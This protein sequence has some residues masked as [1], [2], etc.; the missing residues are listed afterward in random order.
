M[1][2][3]VCNALT[4]N[5]ASRKCTVAGGVKNRIWAFQRDDITGGITRN[6]G[7]ALSSFALATGAQVITFTSK[8]K[9]GKGDNKITQPVDAGVNVEQTVALAASYNSQAEADAIIAFLQ[10]EGKVIFQETNAGTIRVYF[11]DFGHESAEGD[12][13]TGAVIGDPSNLLNI[14]LKGNEL[15]LP[16]FFEAAIS[17][18][19]TQ[20]ASSK[21]YLDALVTGVAVV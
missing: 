10:A 20:L 6:A 18:Q 2:S 7:G 8:A 15:S 1:A 5:I 16:L 9:K 4:K 12:D 21:A 19:L 14:S 13:S 17:G 3:T 11:W